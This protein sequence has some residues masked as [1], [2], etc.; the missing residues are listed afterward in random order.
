MTFMPYYPRNFSPKLLAG[1]FACILSSCSHTPKALD[2]L[3]LQEKIEEFTRQGGYL[4]PRPDQIKTQRISWQH[5]DDTWDILLSTPDQP[6]RYPVVFYMPGLGETAEA[7]QIWRQAWVQSGYAVV[8]VQ[9]A[10]L[11]RALAEIEFNDQKPQD[12]DEDDL[13][14][15]A[16]FQALRE[17]DL[18][19]LGRQYFS[20]SAL[21][22]RV[23]NLLWILEQLK[24]KAE[25][26]QQPFEN[27]DFSR[28][29]LAGYDIGAQTAAALSGED[30]L[31]IAGLQALH[32]TAV[33]L[34]SPSVDLSAGDNPEHFK[35]LTMPMLVITGKADQ[36]PYGISSPRVRTAIWE[37]APAGEK[38][39]LILKS[40]RH[41]LLSGS[42]AR[43]GDKTAESEQFSN[44]EN[45]P[46]EPGF[47]G[48]GENGHD[49]ESRS[50][51]SSGGDFKQ[52]ATIQNVS[53]AF[54][55]AIVKNHK[56]AAVWL[57]NN[58]AQWVGR[59]GSL[60]AK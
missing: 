40:G 32:P 30:N 53:A 52:L 44:E 43:P 22:L 21:K 35:N 47:F 13:E 19:Y 16:R 36:D 51:R 59:T 54:L 57:K 50:D 39:L 3:E 11:G 60:K 9:S 45:Q 5:G 25:T 33:I 8:T 2:P 37:Y 1:L 42:I 23:M 28:L 58:A 27:L 48:S 38:F 31:R 26:R 15:Q 29:V 10:R 7:G 12:K 41:K 4:E 24:Q 14:Q 56:Q 18:H 6:G 46:H 34:L 20:E 17:S 49:R 55:D